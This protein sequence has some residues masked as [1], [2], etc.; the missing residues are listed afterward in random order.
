MQA[1]SMELPSHLLSLPVPCLPCQPWEAKGKK[2][3][4][5]WRLNSSG[6][7]AILVE[8]LDALEAGPR[9]L[10]GLGNGERL[11]T[12]P[13]TS[14]CWIPDFLTDDEPEEVEMRLN[15]KYDD[16]LEG[17]DCL[18][19]GSINDSEDSSWRARYHGQ[20]GESWRGSNG[21]SAT[22]VGS[23]GLSLSSLSRSN[24]S[25]NEMS[26]AQIW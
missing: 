3:A 23:S 19:G 15:N 1:R 9:C 20:C 10:E 4:T 26:L 7:S 16:A 21:T 12:L 5:C 14:P 24:K 25:R 2:H 6:P 22:F 8:V 17:V 18:K 13:L 11:Q